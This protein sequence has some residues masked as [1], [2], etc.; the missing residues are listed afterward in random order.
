[1]KQTLRGLSKGKKV[2]I[3]S[4]ILPLFL[5][6]E[7]HANAQ[8]VHNIIDICTSSQRVMKDYALMGMKIEYH[9]PKKDLDAMVKRMEQEME[10]MEKRAISNALHAEELALHKAWKSIEAELQKKPT[11][12][13]ALTL[14]HHVNTFAHHC[15]VMAEHLAKDS[16]TRGMYDEALLGRINLDVQDLAASYIM[17]AW[18]AE[19]DTEYYKEVK[20][21]LADYQK[22]YDELEGADEKQV[23]AKIKAHLK[24]ANKHFMAFEFMAESRSGRYV[25]LL[26]AKKADKIYTG[27]KKI[28][29]EEESE[30]E[31]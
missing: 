9:N 5:M 10:V 24:T 27:I 31:K 26:I 16:H 17:H 22:A 28:L 12:A 6:A 2:G 14:H 21:I 15:E 20:E 11:K 3:L 19:E 23:S 1:M 18:G 30:V 8:D 4:M 7:V 13:G 25:P 29:K